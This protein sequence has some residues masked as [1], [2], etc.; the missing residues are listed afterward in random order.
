MRIVGW[1]AALLALGMIAAVAGGVLLG[2][3]I[4]DP[5]PGTAGNGS[6][7][8][9]TGSSSSTSNGAAPA[10]TGT[11][12]APTEASC[13]F[14]GGEAFV[15]G[16]VTPLMDLGEVDGLRVEGALYPHP[17]Y[18]GNPWTQ[19]GQG[20]VLEDGRFFSAIGDHLGV[21]GNSYVYEY[22]PTSGNLSMV[23]DVLSYV[24]YQ[25]GSWGY[26]K[27]HGQMVAGSCGEIYFHTYWGSTSGIHFNGSYDG[28]I[29]FRLDPAARTIT[30][31]GVTVAQHGVPSLAGSAANNLVY[32]EALDPLRAQVDVD[33]GPFFA[34]D[35]V[36]EQVVFEGPPTPHALFR[37]IL[38]DADGKAYY[39]MGNAQ[40]AVYDP[41]TNELGALEATMPG[42]TIRA[43]TLPGPDGRV[44]AVTDEPAQFF[45][46]E[47]SGEI[48]VMGEAIG[49]TTSLALDP[50][51]SRFFYMPDAHGIAY[52]YGASVYSIDTETGVETTLLGDLN[53]LVESTLGV[54][55][56][57]SYDLAVSPSGD[58][59][60]IGINVGPIG[61]EF[62]FG[63]VALLIVHLR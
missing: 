14:S 22:D 1:K 26:G 36:S 55:V 32:G 46:L 28:D 45:A 13:D 3:T 16:P 31:L 63:D 8:G 18:E 24:D 23:G 39:S 5:S 48:T 43:S 53:S 19:W 58:R 29:L 49:Y 30:N 61:S 56:G 34:Y 38:V 37:N 33:E 21:G 47:P 20:I 50:D 57:G 6:S 17:A 44:F 52:Y 25:N 51:G 27:I 59:L 41:E 15:G 11:T 9:P 54:E 7:P 2:T 12:R 62:G 60:Y 42:D 10:N 40:L 4:A 35:T